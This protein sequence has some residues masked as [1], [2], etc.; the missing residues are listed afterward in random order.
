MILTTT[1]D[2]NI[3]RVGYLIF[4]QPI[5][6]LDSNPLQLNSADNHTP[7]MVL[8]PL[9]LKSQIEDSSDATRCSHLKEQAFLTDFAGPESPQAEGSKAADIETKV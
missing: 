7:K 5:C 9:C 6:E 2:L 1:S 3:R 4:F 8:D